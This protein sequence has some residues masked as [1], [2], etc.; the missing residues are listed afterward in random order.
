MHVTSEMYRLISSVGTTNALPPPVAPPLI[1]NTGPN[2]G[3][4]RATNEGTP[5]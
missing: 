4:L 5:M 3:S 1:P 2:E